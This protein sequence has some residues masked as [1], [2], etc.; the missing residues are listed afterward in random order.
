VLASCFHHRQP[1]PYFTSEQAF[2][3]ADCE[4]LEGLFRE[5]LPW[6]EHGGSFYEVRN[7]DVTGEVDPPLLL[8]LAQRM[9]ALTGLPLTDRVAV[10]AQIMAP[11]QRI[12]VHSDRPLA[13]FETVR[14]VVQCNRQWRPGDGGVLQVLD[15]ETGNRVHATLAPRFNSA[16]GFVMHPGSYH[17]VTATARPRRSLVFNFWHAGNGPGLADYLATLFSELRF[18]SLPK[19]LD[20]ICMEAEQSLPEELTYRALVVASALRRWGLPEATLV[21]GYKA[22]TYPSA[23]PDTTASAGVAIALAQWAAWLY[24]EGFDLAQWQELKLAL[25]TEPPVGL[26]EPAAFW[27]MAFPKDEVTP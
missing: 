21:D 20:P 18:A 5:D 15:D 8:A 11:G 4:R 24:L 2:T 10:T 9:R 19:A 17:A 23:L 1:Y 6:L 26:P 22:T 3:V 7:C 14:L 12:G 25:L 13:G 16:F 27:R